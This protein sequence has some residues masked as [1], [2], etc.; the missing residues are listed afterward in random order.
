MTSFPQCVGCGYCCITVRCFL[1]IRLSGNVR[2]EYCQF[3]T[4][5]KEQERYLCDL[6]EKY[7]DYLNIGEGCPSNMNSWRNDVKERRVRA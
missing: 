5:S 1:S 7:A 6:A 3:L 4:W 2:T